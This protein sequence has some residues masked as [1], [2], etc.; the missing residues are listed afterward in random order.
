MCQD[1]WHRGRVD[2]RQYLHGHALRRRR[3][4]LHLHRRS[5]RALLA[6]A[7]SLSCRC[8][9]PARL[10]RTGGHC[11]SGQK[12]AVTVGSP[13]S[14]P[15]GPSGPAPAS[16]SNPCF[17]SASRVTFAD[18]TSSTVDTLKEGDR[19]VAATVDGTLT[20]DTVSLLS[21]AHS[22]A[23]ASFVSLTT[24]ANQTLSLTAE[25]HLPV[26]AACCGTLKKAK[27]VAVGETVW[28]VH[29]GAAVPTTVTNIGAT[30]ATG[31]HSPVL[32]NGGFPVVDGVVTSFDSI[33]KVTLAKHGLPALLATC[34][35]TGTCPRFRDLFLGDDRKYVEQS[36]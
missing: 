13:P 32:T 36:E 34:K 17:P 28:A 7:A 25:H 16:N 1:R 31:L 15:S 20:T 35:A 33:D 2:L 3:L 10:S 19:I 9:S 14:G 6:A 12:I 22:D 11:A 18:G 4:L 23:S 30:K 29:A 21:I 5:V 27:D 26:G 8:H 24:T